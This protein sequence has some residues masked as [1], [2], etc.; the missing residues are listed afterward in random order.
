MPDR[1]FAKRMDLSL[2]NGGVERFGVDISPK[3][4]IPPI[5]RGVVGI[6]MRI[7][8]PSTYDDY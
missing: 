3:P 5:M 7:N 2:R 6:G 1:A 4:N 8:H